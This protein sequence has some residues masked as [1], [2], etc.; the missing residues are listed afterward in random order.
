MSPAR[1]PRVG[2]RAPRGQIRIPPPAGPV[3]LYRAVSRSELADI[4]A[5][6][7]YRIL[8]G[9]VEVRYFALSI[10]DARY[11]KDTLPD[12]RAIVRSKVRRQTLPKLGW[13][14][15]D[16]R[17]VVFASQNALA[18]VNSDALLFG[19]IARLE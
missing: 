1:L 15:V 3:R 6:R 13:V 7:R 2:A 17:W 19:G 12:A 5:T 18:A 11:F 9:M 4:G 16:G 10:E 14:Y 8:P